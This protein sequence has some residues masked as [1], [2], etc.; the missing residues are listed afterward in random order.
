[1]VEVEMSFLFVEYE[2]NFLGGAIWVMYYSLYLLGNW[3]ESIVT[4]DKHP[5]NSIFQSKIMATSFII[6]LYHVETIT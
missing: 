5:L 4:E 6:I 1:M 3:K 2:S